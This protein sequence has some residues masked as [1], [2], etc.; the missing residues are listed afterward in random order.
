MDLT[1]SNK[2]EVP[3]QH[4]FT[5]IEVALVL[6]ILI[7]LLIVFYANSN[8]SS[9]LRMARLAIFEA[10]KIAQLAEECRN[11]INNSTKNDSDGYINY[12]VENDDY[13]ITSS[14]PFP[15]PGTPS[16][17][18]QM[19]N[20]C[21]YSIDIPDTTPFDYGS[22][23]IVTI[24]NTYAKVEFTVP[25]ENYKNDE[26]SSSDIVDIG[27]GVDI[28]IYGGIRSSKTSRFSKRAILEKKAFFGEK[29]NREG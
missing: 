1:R 7:A 25:I 10:R 28:T 6:F 2:L 13:E 12:S 14:T 22:D 15:T 3:K 20:R 18:G 11:K 29:V 4:G 16:T 8:K 27:N 24:T 21:G 26:V 5:F 23:Y 9:D 17:V 19:L